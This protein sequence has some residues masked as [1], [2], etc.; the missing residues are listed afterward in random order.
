MADRS[1]D[2]GAEVAGGRLD[3]A[4]G[5]TRLRGDGR[6][7][8]LVGVASWTDRTLTAP[9]VFYPDSVKTPESRL[10]HYAS[11]F[12]LVEVDSTYYAI[13]ATRIVEHWAQ[14]TPD[15]FTFNI[16]AHALMTGHATETARLPSSLRGALPPKLAAAPRVYAKDLPTEL[17][18]EVWRQF[19]A[20]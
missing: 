16:K 3:A 5:N 4:A 20:A 10:R 2:P 13:P 18:D 15:E 14:R 11:R 1:H 12:P 17:R 19:A 9:G 8:I 7:E 6:V